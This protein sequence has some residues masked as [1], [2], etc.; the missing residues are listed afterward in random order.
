M[1]TLVEQHLSKPTG[2][3]ILR[4]KWHK[5]LLGQTS[6]LTLA[7]Q[8]PSFLNSLYYSVKSFIRL[9]QKLIKLL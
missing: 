4:I 6:L 3:L 2:L 8:G 7:S 1:N 5:I 9:T